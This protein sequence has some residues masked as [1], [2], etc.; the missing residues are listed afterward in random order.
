MQTQPNKTYAASAKGRFYDSYSVFEYIVRKCIFVCMRIYT[1]KVSS[2][3]RIQLSYNQPYSL[4]PFMNVGIARK[5]YIPLWSYVLDKCQQ[6][7][8]KNVYREIVVFLKWN[9]KYFLLIL[10]VHANVTWPTKGI[11]D[12][13]TRW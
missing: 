1:Y 3:Y 7:Q 10:L 9:C 4:S 11:H 2:F 6:S 8:M 13:L 5:K 12:M